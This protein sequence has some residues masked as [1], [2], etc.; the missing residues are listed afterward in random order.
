MSI[1]SAYH[2]VDAA[3][4]QQHVDELSAAGFRPVALGVYGDPDDARY[5][6]VWGQRDGPEWWAVHGLSAADYQSKFDE[7]TALGYAPTIVG[8][9]GPIDRAIFAA[10]FEKGVDIGWFARHNLRWDPA[11]DPDTLVHENQRAYDQGYLARCLAIYGTP[12]D[13]RYAGIW[14]ENTGAVLWSWWQTELAAYQRYFDALRDGGLRPASLSVAPDAT[15][16]SVFRDDSVGDWVARHGIWAADYQTEFDAQ[17]AAGRRPIV[18]EAGSPFADPSQA[19]FAAVFATDDA[20]IARRWSATGNAAAGSDTLDAAVRAFMVRNGIRAGSVAVGRNGAI[21]IARAYTWAE[22]GYPIT[23]P[24]TRFRIASVSKMFTAAIV[25]KLVE[26]GRLSWGTN[27]FPLV[28]VTSSLPFGTPVDPAM[29]AITVEQL[30]LRTSRLPRDFDTNDRGVA[31]KIGA[32]AAPLP[33]S[34]LLQY[35]RGLPL[36]AT[37]PAGGLYSNTAFYLLTSVVEQASGF[38]FIDAL[39]HDVLAP[40]NIGDVSVGGTAV[41]TRQPGEVPGYD[42]AD[43]Q[44]S[45]LDFAPLAMAPNV[46]GGAFVIENSAGA[47]GLVTS[48]STI[49]RICA[50]Y[51]V[52]NGDSGALYG[53]ELATR[54]GTLDGTSSGAQSRGDGLDLAFV[55][56][57]RVSDGEHDAIRDAIGAVLD[58]Y[59]G[60]L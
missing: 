50:F 14:V 55:F 45:Q 48:A 6:A 3:T 26:R 30:V 36:A 41:N 37:V 38:A 2:G 15:I 21:V 34:Q 49:A 13:R 46:Y 57:R 32:A 12:E 47:G 54:Y 33:R 40:L 28:G 10:V 16:L 56:N 5:N 35:L 24:A 18:V 23:T 22:P 20:P 17:N 8:A 19:Q 1:F 4:H 60:S 9:T 44:A 25:G 51:P 53:R 27:A 52:W 42:H 29:D 31:A 43:V 7:L 59:G 58:T 39:W 11:E